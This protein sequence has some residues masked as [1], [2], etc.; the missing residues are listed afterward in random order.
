LGGGGRSRVHAES[1]AADRRPFPP[2]VV[3]R[4]VAGVWQSPLSERRAR[5]AISKEIAIRLLPERRPAATRGRGVGADPRGAWQ[6]WVH[7]ADLQRLIHGIAATLGIE[8]FVYLTDIVGLSRE[9]AAAIIRS[10]AL[11]LLRA[12]IADG[13]AGKPAAGQD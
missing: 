13:A 7:A 10:N 8:A 11:G 3:I 1:L 9:E 4:L 2:V 5:I 12:A 6:C